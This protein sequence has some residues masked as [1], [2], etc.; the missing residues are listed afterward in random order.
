MSK[1]SQEKLQQLVS[2]LRE[3]LLTATQVQPSVLAKSEGYMKKEDEEEAC[4]PSPSEKLA[5]EKQEE[6]KDV[7]DPAAEAEK[8]LAVEQK[9]EEA[10]K[11]A[12]KEL[13]APEMKEDSEMPL[14]AEEVEQ[15]VADLSPDEISMLE[16]ALAKM[17]V[18]SPVAPTVS[19]PAPTME[20]SEEPAQV[21]LL[22]SELD[23]VKSALE[24]KE[25]ELA[26]L[27]TAVENMLSGPT[28]KAITGV[29]LTKSE[30]TVTYTPELAKQFL[31]KLIKSKKLD[32]EELDLLV[33]FEN[34]SVSAKSLAPLFEKYNK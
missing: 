4:A 24:A 2:E 5:E 29:N 17:K 13:P 16:A 15:I 30:P 23:L 8:K 28:Y 7:V 18:P 26:R 11:E 32:S 9:P 20:K 31:D 25:S 27:Q 14:S 3:E 21:A 19:A 6:S 1:I 34:G 22:K 33:K 12:P 10:P